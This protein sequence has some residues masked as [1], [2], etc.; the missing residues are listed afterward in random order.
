M[1][2]KNILVVLSLFAIVLA[3]SSSADSPEEAR[4]Y[5][6]AVP[7]WGI[8]EVYVNDA[9][10]FKDGK[11]VANF[12][13]VSFSRYMESVQFRPDG[14]FVGQYAGADT[15]TMLHWE[16]VPEKEHIVVTAADTVQDARS[17]WVITPLNVHKDSFEMTTE[18]AAF[19][20]PRITRIRLK[21]EAKE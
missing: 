7:R 4:E 10:N 18:T 16:I 8:S 13:G 11:E 21:F 12:G 3:C 1:K 20:Y 2:L 6:L 14:A 5:L 9:L 19:D 17:G 15:P